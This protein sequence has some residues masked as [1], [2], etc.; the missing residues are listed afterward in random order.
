MSK[1]IFNIVSDFKSVQDSSERFV[2]AAMYLLFLKYKHT[3]DEIEN[4]DF[5][6]NEVME[7]IGLYFGWG[8]MEQISEFIKKHR[9]K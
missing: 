3:L 9:I 5:R 8:I 1:E 4:L 6:V 7:S 2:T